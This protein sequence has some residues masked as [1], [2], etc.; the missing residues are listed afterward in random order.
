MFNNPKGGDR[1]LFSIKGAPYF[2]TGKK[3]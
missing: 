2:E 3:I 1:L